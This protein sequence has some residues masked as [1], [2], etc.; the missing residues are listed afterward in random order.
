[1]SRANKKSRFSIIIATIGIAIDIIILISISVWWSNTTHKAWWK[2]GTDGETFSFSSKGNTIYFA[3]NAGVLYAVNK[4]TGSIIWQYK[5]D[6]PIFSDPLIS[7]AI[8]N[9]VVIV[10]SANGVI[11]GIN[12]KTGNEVWRYENTTFYPFD[13]PVLYKNTV[14]VSDTYGN[15]FALNAFT[16]KTLWA[17]RS[18]PKRY[19]SINIS[20]KDNLP[21]YVQDAVLV[22]NNKLFFAAPDGILYTLNLKS[23]TLLW[24][25]DSGGKIIHQ[26]ISSGNRVYISNRSGDTIALD[27]KTGKMLWK[28]HKDSSA[29]CFQ[30]FQT[31]DLINQINYFYPLQYLQTMLFFTQKLIDTYAIEVNDKGGIA[32][33]SPKTGQTIWSTQGYGTTTSCPEAFGPLLYFGNKDSVFALR[34]FDGHETWS[35]QQ[36]NRYFNKPIVFANWDILPNNQ[37]YLPA[38]TIFYKPISLYV[39]DNV[40]D[41]HAFSSN[42][43]QQW[44]FSVFGTVNPYPSVDNNYIYF[45]STDGALYRLN[46]RLGTPPIPKQKTSVN[47]TVSRIGEND[48][49]EITIHFDDTLYDN[50]WRDITINAQFTHSSNTTYTINGFYYDKNIWKVR[51]NPP[52]KGQWCWKIAFE[53]PGNTNSFTGSFVST[54][55]TAATFI[56]IYDK[57]PK[58]FTLDNKTLFNGIGIGDAVLDR[59]RNGSPLDDWFIEDTETDASASG[60]KS[61]N[62]YT[63]HKL[64]LDQYLSAYGSQ[65][66][67]NIYR[68]SVNNASFNLWQNFTIN[69]KFLITEGKYGDELAKSLK[70][71]GFQIWMTIFG[72]EIPFGYQYPNELKAMRQYIRYVVARYGPYVSVWEIANEAYAP[73]SLVQ[74][75][76]KEIKAADIENRPI[77]V[78]QI[79]PDMK[80]ISIIAPHW[81][82][83]E[84][85]S[86]S[87]TSTVWEIAK[88][89]WYNKPVVF[90]EQGNLTPDDPDRSRMRMRIRAWTAFFNE[91]ILIFWNQSDKR[92]NPAGLY[93][94]SNLYIGNKER[95][96]IANLQKFTQ[97]VDLSATKINLPIDNPG[98]RGYGL[99]SNNE[100][101]GYFYHYTAQDSSA[102]FSTTVSVPNDAVALWYD[103]VT[104]AT[105]SKQ[106]LT[107]GPN[108][109]SSPDFSVDIALKI[110]YKQQN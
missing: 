70:E 77:S 57:N 1:M 23:G 42:G 64:S 54:T 97:G 53:A 17:F 104:G 31:R 52:L 88:Y 58:R 73:E 13:Q 68:W 41:L 18:K 26:P 86:T 75:I 105:V 40:G 48:V 15:L 22:A 78:S 28:K 65:G 87:D 85:S 20:D 55:D 7:P 50:P 109:V 106:N 71:H 45:S 51:F 62:Y 107:S 96:E 10:T 81:Y 34:L 27:Q 16:G 102:S 19:S 80:E 89:Q 33:I 93:Q 21:S 67:F 38:L 63:S 72:F 56:K 11:Y 74:F 8:N 43:K 90:A 5:A 69:N 110:T 82:Q 44:T 2:I 3:N 98:V 100:F 61:G 32:M 49:V 76:A 46:R 39:A 14:Y 4:E 60:A 108:E 95:S 30:I 79:W 36:Q 83:T 12:K 66:L 94:N 84:D 103:P 91:A 24:W 92:V 6:H 37:K 47:Q 59:N 29:K 99:R 25:Y 9:N 101:V 35:Y